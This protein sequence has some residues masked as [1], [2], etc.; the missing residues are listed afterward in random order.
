MDPRIPDALEAFPFVLPPATVAVRV[1]WL[2]DGSLV[3][4]TGQGERQ[5]LWPLARGSHTVQA[6]V[7]SELHGDPLV[8]PAVEF[9]VK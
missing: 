4:T 9:I 6:Q 1:H 8:T 3:G 7:W 5:F 2:V